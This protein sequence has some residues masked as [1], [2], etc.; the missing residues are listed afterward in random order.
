M[1]PWKKY[2]VQED[3]PFEKLKEAQKDTKLNRRMKRNAI[4]N[5]E[6]HELAEIRHN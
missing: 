2:L 3:V 4:L 6:N 5:L 1:L